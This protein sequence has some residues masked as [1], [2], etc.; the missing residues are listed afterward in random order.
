MMVVG[1]MNI[2]ARKF[3]RS[4]EPTTSPQARSFDEL[5]CQH[6]DFV[7]RNLRRLGVQEGLVEDAAQDAFVVV[8]RRLG[9]LHPDASAKAWLFGIALRVAHDYR[10]SRRRKPA[11]SFDADTH[12]SPDAG[13]FEDAAATEARALLERFLSTLDEPKRAVFVLAELEDMSAPEIS[14]ALGAGTN[15]IYSRLRTARALFVDFLA[16]QEQQR[17]GHG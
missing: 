4:A 11:F 7:W 5:Y 13:P 9:D 8:H 14:Q 1:P 3:A 10:R 2:H 12:V 17:G 6:F 16:Q 15:T